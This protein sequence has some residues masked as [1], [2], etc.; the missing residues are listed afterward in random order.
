MPHPATRRARGPARMGA[1]AST[2]GRVGR[3]GNQPS[4][5]GRHDHQR[6][7]ERCGGG[8]CGGGRCG[9]GRCGGGRRDGERRGD[10]RRGDHRPWRGRVREGREG[11]AV[12]QVPLSAPILSGGGFTTAWTP[13]TWA[14]ARWAGP[15]GGSDRAACGRTRARS[16]RD[17]G[18]A[19]RRE[20]RVGAWVPTR[21]ARVLGSS[22]GGRAAGFRAPRP[23]HP[24]GPRRRGAPAGVRGF[25]FGRCCSGGR[26]DGRWGASH[27]RLR[28][29]GAVGGHV[30]SAQTGVRG[31]EEAV[32]G[33]A[34]AYSPSSVLRKIRQWPG[35][36][37]AGPLCSG[38]GKAGSV[39]ADGW[40]GGGTGGGG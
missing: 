34:V 3:V 18:P 10:D 12:A 25:R 16:G 37:P 23:V 24:R 19:R 1:C 5:D 33:G 21:I 36:L 22:V 13:G 26:G 32:G 30:L 40:G 15:V 8:R 11:V 14:D 39:R 27:W 9:G 17:Q 7:G 2:A 35:R 20:A 38:P 29:L 31:R 4:D 6:G 28:R